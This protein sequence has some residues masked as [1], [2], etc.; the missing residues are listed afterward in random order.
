MGR[1]Y[2]L[3]GAHDVSGESLNSTTCMATLEHE[4]RDRLAVLAPEQ[5]HQVLEYARSLSEVRR[6]G[7]PGRALL[8][9]A[10]QIPTAE[11]QAIAAAV[12]EGCERSKPGDW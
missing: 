3:S 2:L 12:E 9:F 6:R 4:L 7:I 1:R 5:Q 11:A 10:G 8:R